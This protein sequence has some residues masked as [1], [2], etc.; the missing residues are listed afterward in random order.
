MGNFVHAESGQESQFDDPC[1]VGVS[2]SQAGQRF[3]QGNEIDLGLKVRWSLEPGE[4]NTMLPAAALGGFLPS[5]VVSQDLPH[6]AGGNREEVRPILPIRLLASNKLHV[7]L[8]YKG[9]GLK[10]MIA[11]LYLEVAAG[12]GA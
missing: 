1:L 4:R 7:R 2:S 3:I 10:C 8:M 11:T 9:G 6:R 12:Q 5:R